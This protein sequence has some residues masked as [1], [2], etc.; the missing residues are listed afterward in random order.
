MGRWLSVIIAI[1]LVVAGGYWLLN[2]TGSHACY[3][4][5]GSWDSTHLRC[6]D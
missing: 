6:N 4:K 2:R 3:E 1:L 5:G